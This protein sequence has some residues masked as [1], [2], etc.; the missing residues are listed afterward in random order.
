MKEREADADCPPGELAMARD[1][2]AK[3]CLRTKDFVRTRVLL[4]QA[5]PVLETVPQ[6]AGDPNIP[7]G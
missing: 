7:Q 6:L 1:H 5:L 2:A 3:A 4:A